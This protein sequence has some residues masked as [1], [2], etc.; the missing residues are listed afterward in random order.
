MIRGIDQSS[1]PRCSSTLPMMPGIRMM[2]SRIGCRSA[3]VIPRVVDNL[4]MPG[5]AQFGPNLRQTRRRLPVQLRRNR[6]TELPQRS[7]VA[8][9][10][11]VRDELDGEVAVGGL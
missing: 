3:M 4:N 8:G 2:M 5:L 10:V 11:E 6:L 1:L 9:R 7:R